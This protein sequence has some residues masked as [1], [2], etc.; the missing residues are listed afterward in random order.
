MVRMIPSLYGGLY[1]FDGDD[2][3]QI[4]VTADHLLSSSYKF[5]DDLVISGKINIYLVYTSTVLLNNSFRFFVIYKR[6]QRNPFV[7]RVRQ[8]WSYRLRMLVAGLQ[9]HN[10]TGGV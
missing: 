6:R 8:D 1:K 5:S 10:R 2:L 4:P 7:W 3:E 9:E